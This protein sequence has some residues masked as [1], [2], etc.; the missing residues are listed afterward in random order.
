MTFSASGCEAPV[1]EVGLQEEVAAQDL[2]RGNGCSH[3]PGLFRLGPS[4]KLTLQG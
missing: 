4:F 1:Q 2:K 3:G